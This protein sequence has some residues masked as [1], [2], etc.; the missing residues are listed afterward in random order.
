[1]ELT[2][3][4]SSWYLL[5]CAV[6]AGL[7]AFLLYGKN[8]QNAELPI[9]VV[10]TLGILRFVTVFILA[11]LLLNPMVQKWITQSE[12]PIILIAQDNSASI[13]N[14]ADSSYY[15]ND[16]LTQLNQLKSSI[17]KNYQVISLNFGEAVTAQ[18][19]GI[20]FTDKRTNYALL[21]DEIDARFAGENIG[22]LVFASDG[23]YNSG[24]N[25]EYYNFKQTYPVYTIG[26]G[27][28]TQKSDIAIAEIRTNDIVYLG[29]D[30]P[31]EVTLSADLLKGKEATLNVHSNGKLID[32]RDFSITK[33]Q[34]VFTEKLVFTATKEGT[35]RFVFSVTEFDNE[36]NTRNNKQ[37]VLI[38]VLDN[39][40][41]ILIIA[42]APHPDIAALRT[43]LEGKETY[44][45][46]VETAEKFKDDFTEYNL[47]IAHGFGQE[48]HTQ[49]WGDLWNSNVPTWF[50][51][52]GN[53]KPSRINALNPGFS[54]DG[55][56]QKVNR[57]LPAFNSDFND[58]KTSMETQNY[59]RK[60]PPLSSPFAEITG[61]SANQTLLYQKIGSVETSFPLAYF[62]KRNSNK[63][64]WLFGE[65]VWR[66]K[67]FDYQEN[68]NTNHFSEW[69][70]KTV[71]YLSVKEDKSR[72]R[73][74]L[75]KRFNENES[76][77]IQAEFYDKS[78]EKTDDFDVSMELTDELGNTYNYMFN[79]TG[80]GY[81]LDVGRLQPGLYNY[82][83]K[84]TDGTK[85]F[86]KIG[87]FIVE[88]VDV[89]W[90]K[91]SADFTV[92]QKLSSRTNGEFYLP[93][94]MNELAK[95]FEDKTKF[96]SISYTSEKKQ[97]VVHY[98]WIFALIM[99]LLTI[100]WL[101]RK[102]K[103]RY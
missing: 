62:T 72:F 49:L 47:V 68:G 84:V 63:T 18:D 36:L 74:K 6:L 70:W 33:N 85:V 41:K 42:E 40:D 16:Y 26:L 87:S 57:I 94:E 91:I 93:A 25:P 50:V 54:M 28:T 51:L 77:T 15:K 83:A 37:Q 53:T 9:W 55:E 78:Y 7:Y 76:I 103:G 4:Y 89:E 43:V 80:L 73:I 79:P 12:S 52:Y 17:G 67:L 35:Q 69:V 58:F 31:V 20:S 46:F 2:T 82:T 22:A 102:M 24:A 96:P 45:V 71:Q 75:N 39:R 60:V 14:N 65:G 95:I 29:K 97:E 1:M 38:D 19:S 99:L 34:E 11:V 32:K 21:F 3:E 13:L 5:L 48:K 88:P 98:K 100:E 10:Q 59:F 81:F 27:D 8:K 64:A 23:I 66:W 30:F 101:M 61:T 86:K 56:G 92:L 44:E 90:T